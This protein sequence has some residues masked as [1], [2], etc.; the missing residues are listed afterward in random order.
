MPFPDLGIA[1]YDGRGPEVVEL[2]SAANR[3]VRITSVDTHPGS[4]ALLVKTSAFAS[5]G[6]WMGA[7]LQ[8]LA[9]PSML[10]QVDEATEVMPPPESL[11]RR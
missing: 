5:S 9:R 10:K 11:E 1:G 2:L 6:T 7:R 8:P 4:G 3:R